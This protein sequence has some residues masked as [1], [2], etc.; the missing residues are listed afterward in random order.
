MDDREKRLKEIEKAGKI[1][2]AQMAQNE[3]ASLTQ[4]QKNNLLQ[5]KQALMQQAQQRAMVSQAAEM[6]VQTAA[7]L[8]SQSQ[9]PTQQKAGINAQTQQ[10]LSKYGIN[11]QQKVAPQTTTTTR[12]SSKVGATTVENI[13]NTTTTNHNVVRIIQPNIP[14]TQ[15]NIAMRQGAISNAKFKSWLQK[16][17]AQQEEIATSQM[18]EYNRRER[19][20]LRSTDR[21]MRK[22]QDLSKSIG[23]SLDPENMTNT[24]SG[25]LKTLMFLFI[26][27][28][29]PIV[30]K[31][32]MEKIETF[33]A[34][35]RSFFG[36]EL[37]GSLKSK[38]NPAINNWKQSLGLEGD[39]DNAS[40]PGAV[41]KLVKSSFDELM[42]KMQNE[43]EDRKE[44]INQAQQYMPDSL[45]DIEGW[46]KY[47]G[48]VIVAAVGGSEGQA[49]YSEGSRIQEEKV[50]EIENEEFEL[51]GKKISMLG[52]FDEKGNLRNEDSALKLTQSLANETNKETVDLSKIQASVEKLKSFHNKTDKLIPLS[53]EFVQKIQEIVPE[54]RINEL[55][56]KY[57]SRGEYRENNTDYVFTHRKSDYDP[58]SQYSIWDRIN[59]WQSGAGKAGIA[60]GSIAG[61]ATSGVGA[62]P[63]ACIGYMLGSIGGSVIG[64]GHGLIDMTQAHLRTPGAQ[65]SLVPLSGLSEEEKR[66]MNFHK[67]YAPALVQEV[68][69]E[70][71]QELLGMTKTNKSAFSSENYQGLKKTIGTSRKKMVADKKYH[72]AIQK[73][74]K[75]K[76]KNAALDREN[77]QTNRF[78][79]TA[80]RSL[81]VKDAIPS[82]SENNNSSSSISEQVAK[83]PDN[84]KD[85]ARNIMDYF[86]KALGITEEQAAGIAGNLM[87]ESS[88]NEKAV[89]KSS[90]A[91]G[92]AQWLGPRKKALHEKFGDNPSF[93]QQLNFI[94]EELQTTEKRALNYLK[95]ATT[96]EDSTKVF[97]AEFERPGWDDKSRRIPLHYQKRLGYAKSFYNVKGKTSEVKS[98]TPTWEMKYSVNPDDIGFDTL[99]LNR[100]YIANYIDNATL[101]DTNSNTSEEDKLKTIADTTKALAET[102]AVIAAYDSVPP[103][104]IINVNGHP[105]S[106]MPQTETGWTSQQ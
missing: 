40:V 21:M 65:L 96:V 91:K 83:V 18:N 57:N 34:N 103:H 85:T 87:Q 67:N 98:T 82:R 44:A 99:N 72:N 37:P 74:I 49:V 73:S 69:P 22:L 92:L 38:A 94:V 56:K 16:A 17:N 9:A 39:L 55:I 77:T 3:I 31:P 26:T 58:S 76:E 50:K 46:A 35:F 41:L 11:P 105:T 52:E 19:S 1:Q 28:M 47:L 10:I 48:K 36:M 59:Q 7:D 33:E 5:E 2:G 51:N 70:F 80:D 4:E 61:A 78:F 101:T 68:S 90:G 89:N 14:V 43:A 20:L 75:V 81:P 93:S 79:E 30:W 15:P 25:S 27:T 13:T 95:Q 88:L 62:I 86:K 29:I 102:S 63:G 8:S 104:Q 54:E 53:P 24:I 6:G 106:V 64:L 84:I 23:T 32:I 71:I 66:T 12:N 42:A 97:G 100:N 60:A 45:T